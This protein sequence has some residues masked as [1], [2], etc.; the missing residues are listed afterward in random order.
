MIF[1][2]AQLFSISLP[3]H[4]CI[5]IHRSL[6]TYAIQDS[7][8]LNFHCVKLSF[9][10]L[11]RPRRTNGGPLRPRGSRLRLRPP[12]PGPPGPRTSRRSGG[13]P[14][15]G[16]LPRNW[17]L[18]I[19][20]F[21]QR[22]G[23]RWSRSGNLPPPPRRSALLLWGLSWW[24][25]SLKPVISRPWRH[26]QLVHVKHTHRLTCT[27]CRSFY[28]EYSCNGHL[29]LWVKTWSKKILAQLHRIFESKWQ[30]FDLEAVG[31]FPPESKL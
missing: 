16:A 18:E 21:L 9:S 4:D 24:R 19:W 15:L 20:M 29:E 10:R 6:Y 17:S 1:R 25:T 27:S 14:R 31:V 2:N 5:T 22:L 12:R 28:G 8:Q 13:P 23:P 3:L 7:Q 30:H 11:S 26:R